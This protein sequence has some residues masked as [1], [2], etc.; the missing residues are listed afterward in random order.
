MT[1]ATLSHATMTQT[2]PFD[3]DFDAAAKAASEQ[4]L[5]DLR[6]NADR[7]LCGRYLGTWADNFGKKAGRDRS[8][9]FEDFRAAA[10]RLAA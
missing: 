4:R 3:F 7:E 5:A 1:T 8:I 10:D 6:R 2:L 9:S